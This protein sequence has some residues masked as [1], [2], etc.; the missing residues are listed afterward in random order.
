MNHTIKCLPEF[1]R[2]IIDGSKTFECRYN[3]RHYWVDDILIIKEWIPGESAFSGQEVRKRVSY[4]LSGE[5]WGVVR[6]YCVLGLA[7]IGSE[8]I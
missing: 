1:Y 7:A 5:E 8:I 4:L 2:H 6:G 3:D